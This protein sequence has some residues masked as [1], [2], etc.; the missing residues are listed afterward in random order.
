MRRRGYP[1]GRYLIK[2]K[3]VSDI[4][5]QMGN[6]LE[7]LGFNVVKYDKKNEGKGTLLI[8]V[9]KKVMDLIKQKKPSGYLEM[10]LSGLTIPSQRVY[11]AESQ[12]VGIEAYLWPIEEG[13]LL[14]LFVLPYMEH[15]DKFEIFGLTESKEEEITDWFLCEQ[16]WETLEPKILNEFSAE[17]VHRRA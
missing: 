13:V 7:S 17:L 15:M 9:N 11:Y 1:Y 2:D 12:R 10:L 5:P 16:V 8:A 3:K 4:G 14:E 6:Y